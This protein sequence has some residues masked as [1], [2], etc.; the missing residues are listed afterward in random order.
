MKPR[1]VVLVVDDSPETLSFLT[2][3]LEEAG[4][5]VLVALDGRR[6]LTLLEQVTPDVILMDAIMPGLD[7]FE[8]CR[9]LKR[10]SQVAHVPVIFMTGLTETEHILKGFSAGGVDYVTKPIVAEALI[11]RM[12][13]HLANARVA[14]STRAALDATGRYLL[15]ANHRGEVLWCTPQTSRMLETA[16]GHGAQEAGFTLPEEARSWLEERQRNGPARKPDTVVVPTAT[17]G[18]R[19]RISPV[20]QT[21]PDELLLQLADET[22][23]GEDARLKQKL[24]LTAREA[25]VLMWVAN[26]KPNRD[27]AEILGLSPRTVDKH[28]EQIY[29]KLG[30]ENRAAAAAMAVR[31]LNTR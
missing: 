3:S 11:A 28:L 16:F 13:A 29:A 10:N 20:G 26:G 2:D 15:A 8:T 18:V 17:P 9:R 22:G 1:D 6:A 5:T 21:G 31:T 30:V 12:Y 27:I 4:V 25:E 7:G 14:Q 24:A 19:L 23:A